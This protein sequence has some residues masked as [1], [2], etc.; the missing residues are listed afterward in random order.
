MHLQLFCFTAMVTIEAEPRPTITGGPLHGVYEFHQL[1][2][3]WGD[4]DTMGSEDSI[5]GHSFPMELH[6]VFYKKNYRNIRSA[7]DEKDGLTV[8]AFFYHV[9]VQVL[10]GFGLVLCRKRI[11]FFTCLMFFCFFF[12]IHCALVLNEFRWTL[13]KIQITLNLLSC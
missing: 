4:N 7:M 8:L 11:F 10:I 1:H 12:C 3:H 6:M 9:S 2:F 5:D 13:K